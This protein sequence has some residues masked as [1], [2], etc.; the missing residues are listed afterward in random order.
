MRK[1]TLFPVLMVAATLAACLLILEAGLRIASPPPPFDPRLPLHPLVKRELHPVLRGVSPVSRFTTNKW[2]MR[3]DSPPK[4]WNES[5]TIVAVGGSTTECFYLDDSKTWPAQLQQ[6]LRARHPDS[7]V[8]NGGLDGHSTRG[9]IVLMDKVVRKIKPD[10]VIMLAG[11]NDLGYSLENRDIPLN[12]FERF[13]LKYWLF[14][15]SR[16]VQLLH[17]WKQVLFNRVTVIKN[18]AHGTFEPRPMQKPESLP[19]RLEEALPSFPAYRENLKIIIAMARQMNVRLLFMTQP[20]LFDDTP[21]WR[22]IEGG[23]YWIKE[24]DSKV[25]APT[26]WK[27]LDIFNREMVSVCAG[28]NVPCL[29]LA[30]R[31]PHDERYFY[32]AAHFTEAG[33]ALVADTVAQYLEE[34]RLMPY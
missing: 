21:A 7:W 5:F 1:E 25:S 9:H 22:N 30:S 17:L 26:V 14:G 15:R 4:N 11:I 19:A 31:I 23:M 33:A 6:R 34:N 12:H 13:H 3:G 2:G 27:M 29:D 20:L 18:T 24:S 28:E 10:M 16:L 32:D 8:G